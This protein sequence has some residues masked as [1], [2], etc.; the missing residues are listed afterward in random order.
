LA[1]VW[2]FLSLLWEIFVTVFQTKSF[3]TI[4]LGSETQ[5]KNHGV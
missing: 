5:E 4:S 3:S 1:T 2:R